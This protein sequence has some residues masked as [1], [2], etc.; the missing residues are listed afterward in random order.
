MKR[1][2]DG[3]N[4]NGWGAWKRVGWMICYSGYKHLRQRLLLA[5]Y[6][7]LSLNNKESVVVSSKIH[8]HA[9]EKGSLTGIPHSLS[10]WRSHK[11]LNC[12]SG[13]ETGGG[14]GS[15]SCICGK[16]LQGWERGIKVR[17]GY[18]GRMLLTVY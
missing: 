3:S 13:E 4:G 12:W 9:L 14:S 5:I 18:Y 17:I 1:D 15:D 11:W 8:V 2:Y 6:Q 10:P 16:W 7:F